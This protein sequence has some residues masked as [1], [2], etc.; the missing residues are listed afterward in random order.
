LSSA[1]PTQEGCSAMVTRGRLGADQKLILWLVG[2]MALLIAGVVLLSPQH[3]ADDVTPSSTNTGPLGVKAAYLTLEGLGHKTSR[4]EKPLTELNDALSDAQVANTTLVLVDPMFDATQKAPF[5]A[6]VTRFLQRGGH[7]LTTGHNGALLLGGKTDTPD[8]LQTVC[9]TQPEGDSALARAGKVQITNVGGWDLGGES[10]TGPHA[11]VAQ[12]C[13]KNV[14]VVSMRAEN[15]AA[16]WWSSESPLANAELKK[17]PALKLLLASVDGAEYSQN[18]APRDVIFIEGLHKAGRDKWTAT[19]GLPIAWL[20]AQVA[21]LFVLLVFSFSRRRGPTRLPVGVPR[22][23]PVE[24]AASMGD[25]YEKGEASSAV[26]EAAR[27]RLERVLTREVGLSHE[28]IK[29][30]PDAVAKAL[31]ERLGAAAKT[32]AA[33]I[34]RHLQEAIEASQAKISPKSTLKLAQALS[35]DAETLRAAIAPAKMQSA[36]EESGTTGIKE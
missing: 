5:K 29:A 6:A 12:R 16:V 11:A 22:S 13:G 18:N 34:A 21:L 32:L 17:D 2:V 8:I 24:F 26:T 28:T 33:D 30:G 25:L 23:S 31:E 3:E 1:S 20:C 9:L 15:G 36:A 19:K 10:A 35:E 27:R 14:V 7:V 4:W